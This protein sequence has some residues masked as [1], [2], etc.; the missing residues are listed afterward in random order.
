MKKIFCIILISF[1]FLSRASAE[2]EDEFFFRRGMALYHNKQYN[3][4]IEDFEK[5]LR[6]NSKNYNAANML[7]K[8]YRKNKL[9]K[10]SL[11][12]YLL[13]LSI[14]P[15]QPQTHYLVGTLYDYFF[16]TINSVPHY[17]K[18]IELEPSHRYAHLKLVRHYLLEKKDLAHADYHFDMSFNLGK[19]D[20][21]PFL[22]AAEKFY[23]AG[24]ENS[25]LEYYRKAVQKN[26]ADLESYF[27]ISE[28]YVR[29]KDY[30]KAVRWLEKVTY[31]RPDHEKAYV[32]L[33]NLYY[34]APLS[35]NKKFSYD[36]A[37]VHLNTAL[38]L[39]PNNKD[40]IL[41]LADVYL[42]SG[43]R[44]DAEKLYKKVEML[45]GEEKK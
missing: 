32:R 10:K 34:T 5:A 28:I 41:L 38:T 3:F 9:T 6:V 33:G 21:A 35:Q 40:A 31:I 29:G 16:S 22:K 11:D 7:G 45:E 23:A 44:E 30:R 18:A 39:N 36:M 25:A 37:I 14:N 13:S 1:A 15:S 17:L 43:K 4:A 26:P 8:I 24:D 2:T 42:K 12:Y 19:S 27:R 20:A